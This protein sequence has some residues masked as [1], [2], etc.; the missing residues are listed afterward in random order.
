LV[1]FFFHKKTF[2]FFFSKAS[3]NKALVP[4]G[5]DNWRLQCL[6]IYYTGTVVAKLLLPTALHH[7][8]S[9]ITNQYKNFLTA[10]GC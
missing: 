4:S 5:Q 10:K 7:K 9:L 1:L 2:H 3:E 6:T 8:K